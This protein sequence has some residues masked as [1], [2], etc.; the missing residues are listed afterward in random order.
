MLFHN[1]IMNVLLFLYLVLQHVSLH[2]GYSNLYNVDCGYQQ[3]HIHDEKVLESGGL[4]I[5]S[6]SIQRIS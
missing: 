4:V 5:L 3:I 1:L 2:R 6:L